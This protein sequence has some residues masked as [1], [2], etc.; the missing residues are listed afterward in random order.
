[1]PVC[2]LKESN[3]MFSLFPGT[4]YVLHLCF[5]F[6]EPIQ[7]HGIYLSLCYCSK[8]CSI[9]VFTWYLYMIC[10]WLLLNWTKLDYPAHQPSPIGE[11]VSDCR[12]WEHSRSEDTQD[13]SCDESSPSYS[14][15]IHSFFHPTFIQEWHTSSWSIIYQAPWGTQKVNKTYSEFSKIHWP[16]L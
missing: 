1:M 15:F 3:F 8:L 14:V 16:A 9:P 4:L 7:E 10:S 11:G 13:K 2:G 5:A 12:L 6:Q